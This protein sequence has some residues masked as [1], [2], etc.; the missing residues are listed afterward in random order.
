[1]LAIPVF[2]IKQNEVLLRLS[3][4]NFACLDWPGLRRMCRESV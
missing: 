1:M 3:S 2:E 4:L